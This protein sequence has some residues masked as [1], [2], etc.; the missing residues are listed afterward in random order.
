MPEEEGQTGCGQAKEEAEAHCSVRGGIG[1]GLST[2]FLH[3]TIESPLSQ[4]RMSLI[5]GPPQSVVLGPAV[6]PDSWS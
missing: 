6:P 1:T 2:G 4:D 5:K 3:S